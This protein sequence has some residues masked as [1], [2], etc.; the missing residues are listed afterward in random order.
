MHVR[1]V[2]LLALALAAPVPAAHADAPAASVRVL[3]CTPWQEG[4]GG[5]VT[6]AARMRAVRGTERMALR[7]ALFEKFGDGE[8]RRVAAGAWHTSRA[9]VSAFNWE[10][11]VD[12]LRQGGVYRAMVRYRWFGATGDRIRSERVRSAPCRQSGRLANLRVASIETRPGD[13]EGTAVYRVQIANRGAAEARRVGV[14]LRVDGEVVDEVELL[15]ALAPNEVRTVTFNGPRCR[16]H[17]R[18]VVD[19]KE[20]I[21]ESREQDNVRAPTCL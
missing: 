11:H 21:P 19:P 12:G 7:I 2:I 3:S 20:L 15:E 4:D 1:P 9:G 6:Y 14:L 5:S 16:R 13:V 10:H 17:L 18:V 8:F